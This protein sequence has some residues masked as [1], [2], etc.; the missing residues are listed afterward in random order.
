MPHKNK[1]RL[2]KKTVLLTLGRLPKGLDLARCLAQAGWRVIVAEPGV[3]HLCGSSNAVSA[4]FRVP[5]P[6]EDPEAYLAKLLK[7]VS[8][9]EVDLVLPV[10][11]EI[12]HVAALHGRLPATVSLA[13]MPLDRLL[14]VHGKLSFVEVCQ[15]S[16]LSVPD[17]FRLSDPQ[18]AGLVSNYDVVIKREYS[19]AGVGLESLPAGSK[20]PTRDKPR[21]WL[22]QQRIKGREL[23]SFSIAHE[24]RALA[25]VV[26]RGT[27]VSGTVAVCFERIDDQDEVLR[28]VNSFITG[29]RVSGFIGLDLIVDESGAVFGLECNPRATSGLHFFEPE[30]LAQA[31]TDP[32][33]CEAVRF[34]EQ[35]LMQQFYPCLT[36]TQLSLF[37]WQ[38][39]KHNL[40]QLVRAKDVSWEL[41]DPLPFLLLPFTAW[42]ILSKTLFGGM[43]FGEAATWDI[44]WVA[45]EESAP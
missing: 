26:Y 1:A 15:R 27:V 37:R 3:R 44:E 2:S 14:A 13:A 22:V 33:N 45:S 34:R 5:S 29:S 36:E 43:S 8:R 10:S 20:L 32:A 40:G 12:L 30:D 19:C 28:W 7:I 18:A 4:S 41:A 21:D 38:E 25:T 42:S 6:A 16:G 31:V 24:G 39:F 35:R 11:E 9:E 23:C 17:T